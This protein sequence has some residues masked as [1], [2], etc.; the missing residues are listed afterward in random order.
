M[1]GL[2]VLVVSVLLGVA[3]HAGWSA[4]HD[5][6]LPF[7]HDLF[8]DAA[9]AQSMIDGQFPADPYYKGERNWYNPLGPG[10]VALFSRVIGVPPV[11]FYARHGAWAGL[12]IPLAFL[13]LAVALF[14]RWGGAL[15]LFAFLF[16]APGYISAWA[17]P[18]YSPWL[19]ANLISVVPFA[20]TLTTALSARQS[21]RKLVW[22]GCGFLLG[23]TFLA[24][25]ASAVTAGC[26]V[27]ALAWK[28]KQFTANVGRCALI[29]VAALVASV[30]FLVSI[31]GYYHLQIRNSAPI[32]Y[33]FI[34][35]EVARFGE[36]LWNSLTLGNIVALA[37]LVLLFVRPAA[38]GIRT[39]FIVWIVL[40]GA[41]FTLGYA[42]QLW[43]Q[44]KLPALVPSF[45]WLSQLRLAVPLLAGYALWSF[46]CGLSA[47]VGRWRTVP[48]PL[49]ATGMVTVFLFFVYPKFVAR[50]DF[51]AARQVALE[52]AAVPGATDT[53]NWMRTELPRDA[54]VLASP[55]DS[56]VLLGAS[57]KK[58][59]VLAPEF[60][61]PY[62]PYGPRAQ[63][64]EML[65]QT[66]IAHDGSGF[67]QTASQ[68]GVSFI[69]LSSTS[70]EFLQASISAPFVT[71]IFSS[72][73]YVV[74]R[75]EP[76]EISSR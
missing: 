2:P 44:Y 11:E 21:D 37:G 22:I 6:Q 38:P 14:G 32:D 64:A 25:T 18:S 54:V 3:L 69:L 59:V 8:R 19:F 76:E 29:L 31:A 28:R 46:C 24:H 53:I 12:V 62:V 71:P 60:S 65:F 50:Y 43:P 48:G 72:G 40:A 9:S 47:L 33:I 20:L 63:A 51:T 15:A 52:C 73:A 45:H 61:N 4:T 49:L 5:L 75:L 34:E 39:I 58:A 30:P 23:A 7:D 27:V 17:A 41:L 57:G 1:D 35:T 10:F 67:R 36:L 66:L 13:I 70:A 42:R 26:V 74:L 56:L 16:L 55:D 68:Y